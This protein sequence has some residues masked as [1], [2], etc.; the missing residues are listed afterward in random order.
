M[1]VTPNT[2]FQYIS[3]CSFHDDNDFLIDFKEHC[4]CGKSYYD[5]FHPLMVVFGKI[6]LNSM[7]KQINDEI[8][9]KKKETSFEKWKKRDLMLIKKVRVEEKKKKRSK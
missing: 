1:L 8:V 5:L 2:T 7:S 6:L 4:L 3:E 9:A